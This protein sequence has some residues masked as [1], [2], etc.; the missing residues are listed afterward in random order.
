MVNMVGIGDLTGDGKNDIVGR[1][2]AGDLY[3]YAGT[4]TGAPSR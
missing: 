1:T 4:G 2:T 3:R